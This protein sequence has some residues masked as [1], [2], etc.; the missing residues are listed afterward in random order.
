LIDI[1]I[2]AVLASAISVFY[3]LRIIIYMYMKEPK[4]DLDINLNN[5]PLFLVMFLCLY[6]VLQLGLFPR[7]VLALVN[8]AIQSLPF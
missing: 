6:F 1:L 4:Q 3:Y 8:Q 5:F 2:I 7:N